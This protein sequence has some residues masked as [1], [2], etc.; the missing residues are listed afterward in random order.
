M[1]GVA[2]VPALVAAPECGEQHGAQRCTT[3]RRARS[4]GARRIQV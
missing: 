1:S 2:Q 3:D 4:M